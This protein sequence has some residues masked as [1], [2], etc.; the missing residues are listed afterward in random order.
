METLPSLSLATALKAIVP[1][2]VATVGVAVIETVGGAL[3]V[4]INV[5]GADMV[6]APLWSIA[7]AVIV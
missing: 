2:A 5:T 1:G 6:D 3:L 7:L 4:T